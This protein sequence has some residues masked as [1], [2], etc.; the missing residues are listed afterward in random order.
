MRSSEDTA[1]VAKHGKKK[2]NPNI[3]CDGYGK[4][5]HISCQCK[6]NKLGKGKSAGDQKGATMANVAVEDDFAFCGDDLALVASP[7]SWLSDSACISHI[8]WYKSHLLP[9]QL[10]LDIGFLDLAMFLGLDEG[11]SSYRALSMGNLIL[12]P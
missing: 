7:D 4:K 11:Q 9:I 1:L 5:G 8:A 6:E 2:I 3:T 10:L 12:L